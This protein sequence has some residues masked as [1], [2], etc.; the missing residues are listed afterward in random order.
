MNPLRWIAPGLVTLLLVAVP[1]VAT[2]ATQVNAYSLGLTLDG[3]AGTAGTAPAPAPSG[4]D[5]KLAIAE[6]SGNRP[7]TVN[8]VVLSL[9]GV[10]L[11]DAAVPGC[12]E[13]ALNDASNTTGLG[14]CPAASLVG[15]T[16]I[17]D[18]IGPSEDIS[19]KL[20][21]CYMSGALVKS[22]FPGHLLLWLLGGGSSPDPA[23]QCVVDIHQALVATVTTSPMGSVV[24]VA[25]PA[26]LAH[27]GG[28]G[29]LDSGFS[30][31]HLGF[32]KPTGPGGYTTTIACPSA[33]ADVTSDV[34]LQTVAAPPVTS[35]APP[36][37]T[38]P[39]VMTPPSFPS[40]GASV[41]LVKS[42]GKV[43]LAFTCPASGQCTGS[44]VLLANGRSVG[45]ATFAIAAGA[46]QKV[47]IKLTSAGRRM[48]KKGHGR[49]RVALV[50]IGGSGGKTK[51]RNLTLKAAK[52]R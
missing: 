36:V 8:H 1:A 49:L 30:L 48:L 33:S 14:V 46:S 40:V 15:T 42:D 25:I 7:A 11:D 12:D 20:F 45:T 17:V 44:A 27:P 22:T 51:T 3:T 31:I 41:P 37:V 16:E 4:L 47:V 10:H 29:V 28:V 13:V 5:V 9:A 32:I 26:N 18:G 23:K 21:G 6:T 35:C 43:S 19:T 2:A 34:G 38:P 39:P 24:D 52:H 50:V